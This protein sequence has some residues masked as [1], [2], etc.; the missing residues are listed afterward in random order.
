MIRDVDLN[1][2]EPWDIQESGQE[3]TT[4]FMKKNKEKVKEEDRRREAF[5]GEGGEL[6]KGFMQNI[7]VR[8]ADMA[9]TY[10]GELLGVHG[11]CSI[12]CLS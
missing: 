6:D 4:T 11:G 3:E 7:R 8:A 9:T 10:R 5:R 12:Q 2:L 1:K